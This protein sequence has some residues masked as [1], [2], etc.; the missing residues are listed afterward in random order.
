[1]ILFFIFS[2]LLL[3]MVVVDKLFLDLVHVCKTSV[4]HHSLNVMVARDN[5]ITTKQ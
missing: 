5:V 2:I 3:D 1:M 4:Q